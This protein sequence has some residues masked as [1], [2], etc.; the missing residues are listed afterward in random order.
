[1]SD[2]YAEAY[3]RTHGMKI[4]D[5]NDQPEDE[6]TKGQPE[7]EIIEQ[8]NKEPVIGE[9]K[10]EPSDEA[11]EESEEDAPVEEPEEEPSET[12]KLLEEVA[13]LRQQN[14]VWAG[15]VKAADKRLNEIAKKPEEKI[16]NILNEDG[17]LGEGFK[18][19]KED[20]PELDSF[21]KV[22]QHQQGVINHYEDKLNE[23]SQQLASVQYANE[24]QSATV[25]LNTR[26]PGYL[27]KM[28]KN[29]WEWVQKTV[30]PETAQ[31]LPNSN[32]TELLSS[33]LEYYDTETGRLSERAQALPNE[34]EKEQEKRNKQLAAT[35]G[36]NTRSGAVVT[37]GHKKE[38]N[39]D[40]LF[41]KVYEKNRFI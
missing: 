39:L 10:E 16:E 24:R 9:T 31:I 25:E 22:L 15:R 27:D 1:M 34:A 36:V 40:D 17:T 13:K 33:V 21:E 5:E 4:M 14:L 11:T 26:W 19:L 29:F 3:N 41:K 30:P 6:E 38:E 35:L 28:D 7:E 8:P 12:T 32:D 2:A 20:Y 18:E 23:I 37:T